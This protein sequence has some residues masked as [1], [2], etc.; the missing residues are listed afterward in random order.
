[1]L[2]V[3]LPA[4]IVFSALFFRIPRTV[5][6]ADGFYYLWQY[7][8]SADT[9]TARPADFADRAPFNAV[10]YQAGEERWIKGPGLVPQAL[11]KGQLAT[12]PFLGA[13]YFL[14][15]AI[16]YE[17]AFFSRSG[18]ELW[19]KKFFAYPYSDPAGRIV[20]ML[21][22]DSNRVDLIDANG[23]PAGVRQVHGNYLTDTDFAA[24]A[25]RAALAFLNGE[26]YVINESGAI[27]AH[28][29]EG[30]GTHAT[31]F[32]SAA[33]S[34]DGARVAVH[35]FDGEKDFI[36]VWSLNEEGRTS[37]IES[38]PL[39]AVYPHLLPL[40]VSA[41]GVLAAAPDRTLYLA[42]ESGESYE[43]PRAPGAPAAI[44]RPVYADRDFFAYGEGDALVLLDH[45]GREL[46]A[47]RLRRTGDAPWRI[48]PGAVDGVFAVET[49]GAVEFFRYVSR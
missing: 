27:A 9:E 12:V 17:T 6:E 8:L 45:S 35:V 3:A 26:M 42:L 38:F 10:L 36:R 16:G 22:G 46:A 33:I 21:T 13:G 18:E 2:R 4:L 11:E 43:K 19:R 37:E 41:H 23:S 32:K 24:R 48:L 44:Y 40:A 47:P 49:A 14:F 28:I 29:R 15:S 25:P 30:D 34:P 1:M 5:L 7:D 31:F 20:L 39:P